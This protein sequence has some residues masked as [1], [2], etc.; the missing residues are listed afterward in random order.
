[1][2]ESYINLLLKMTY[3]TKLIFKRISI[4]FKLGKFYSH[5]GRYKN[6]TIKNWLSL[7]TK[8]SIYKAC[9]H[10]DVANKHMRYSCQFIKNTVYVPHGENVYLHKKYSVIENIYSKKWHPNTYTPHN[11]RRST[12]HYRSTGHLIIIWRVLF[13]TTSLLLP[14]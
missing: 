3:T 2:T 10:V 9:V 4:K 14:M 6:V 13:Y 11:K 12:S 1:M 7:L 5:K 8:V